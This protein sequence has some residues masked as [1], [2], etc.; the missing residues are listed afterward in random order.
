[1]QKLEEESGEHNDICFFSQSLRLLEFIEFLFFQGF[2]LG[3]SWLYKC[4]EVKENLYDSKYFQCS[5][6]EK[7][8][9]M[10]KYESNIK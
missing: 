9:A 4:K 10:W 3:N 7:T 1:M 5:R 6:M 8:K 2:I